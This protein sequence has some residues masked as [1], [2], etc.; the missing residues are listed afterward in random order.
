[1]VFVYAALSS[2]DALIL[3]VRLNRRLGEKIFTRG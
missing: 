3:L 1:M 2:L